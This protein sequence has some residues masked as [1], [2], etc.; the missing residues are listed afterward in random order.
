M[1]SLEELLQDELHAIYG[2]LNITYVPHAN[3][4][5][6]FDLLNEQIDFWLLEIVDSIKE[7]TG[8]EI[9]IGYDPATHTVLPAAWII[10][11]E[12]IPDKL[13]F[14][15]AIAQAYPKIAFRC[16]K[17]TYAIAQLINLH[18]T[19]IKQQVPAWWDSQAKD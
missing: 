9:E 19:V 8:L 17:M 16:N 12:F 3:V 18:C 5:L 10:N 4:A 2:N 6:Y 13:I 7:Y 14:T 15:G 1:V 11:E